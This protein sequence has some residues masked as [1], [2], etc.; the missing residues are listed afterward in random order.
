MDLSVAETWRVRGQLYRLE[1]ARCEEC[2][3]IHYPPMPACPYCGSR[4]LSRVR[5]PER[6]QLESYTIVYSVPEGA[7]EKSPVVLGLVRLG[8]VRVVAELTDVSPEEVDSVEE[9]EA[10]LRRVRSDR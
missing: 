9:V 3:R 2:G 4:R 5:L 8:D 10:V 7:R 6:G 1:A